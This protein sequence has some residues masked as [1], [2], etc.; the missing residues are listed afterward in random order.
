MARLLDRDQEGML[1]WGV[2]GKGKAWN[3]MLLMLSALTRI[4]VTLTVNEPNYT[5]PLPVL[6]APPA[7][8]P[9]DEPRLTV[10]LTWLRRLT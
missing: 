6:I 10:G 1:G 2:G 5:P 8:E 7:G 3:G 4:Q 9:G